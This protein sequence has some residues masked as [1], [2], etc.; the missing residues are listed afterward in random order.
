MKKFLLF[1][2]I[3]LLHFSIL[4]AQDF[5]GKAIYHSKTSVADFNFGGREMSE[6]Q[7]KRITE[8]LKEQSEKTFILTF[9]KTAAIYEEEEKL[10]T[11]GRENGGRGRFRFGDFSGGKLYK[12]IKDQNYA[13]ESEMFGKVF[14]IKDDLKQ[15]NWTMGSET[16]KI[17]NYTCYKA[18]AIQ[19]IDSTD[20]QT[21]RR[22]RDQ[23]RRKEN[24]AKKDT[25]QNKTRIFKETEAVKE[26]EI[27]AWFTPE[28]PVSQGPGEYWGLPG[29]ILEVNAGNTVLLCTK[30]VLNA[31][32]KVEI[33]APAK[34]KVISQ[35]E[36]N[37][38]L[39]TKMEEMSERFRGGNRG[40]GGNSNRGRN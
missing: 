9:D 27:T 6:E 5:Q 16:K 14:L 39:L 30:I 21:L 17:G 29:L 7:K 15:L 24:T 31:D 35:Q 12:N 25:T 19:A 23:E 2:T 4:Q 8:R 38:T 28:I 36:Y 40:P 26:I 13:K 3:C 20:F 37:E 11:P 32:E 10:E 33:K 18:T 1:I 22:K 34:G